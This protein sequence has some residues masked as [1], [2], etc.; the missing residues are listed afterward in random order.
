MFRRKGVT[1]VTKVAPDHF[2]RKFKAHVSVDPPT[3][4]RIKSNL[5]RK[6]QIKTSL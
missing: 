5:E 3:L 4:S 6:S 1:K 2:L